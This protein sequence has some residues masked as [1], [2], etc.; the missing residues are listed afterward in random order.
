M[1]GARGKTRAAVRHDGCLKMGAWPR[2]RDDRRKKKEKMQ[3]G[4]VK[5]F[6]DKNRLQSIKIDT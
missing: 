3:M 1:G 4:R 2:R 5:D 6:S